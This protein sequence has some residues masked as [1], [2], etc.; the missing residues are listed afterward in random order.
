[1]F[2][3]VV[4]PW[5]TDGFALAQYVAERW[6][7][8]EIVIASGQAKPASDMMPEHATFVAKPFNHATIFG[9]FKNVLSATEKPQNH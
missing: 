1:L 8:I 5:R 9:H 6:P 2:S 3:D 4:M 7:H